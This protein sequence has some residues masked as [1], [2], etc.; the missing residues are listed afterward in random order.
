MTLDVNHCPSCGK[1]LSP[2]WRTRCLHCKT[3]FA[4]QLAAARAAA[5]SAARPPNPAAVAPPSIEVDLA[6][7]T[8]QWSVAVVTRQY[9]RRRDGRQRLDEEIKVFA[10]HAYAPVF[11]TQSQGRLSK[12]EAALL[13][14]GTGG[15]AAMSP[16]VGVGGGYLFGRLLGKEALDEK[17]IL[18]VV[19]KRTEDT[20]VSSP[21]NLVS[22]LAR[23]AEL[24]DAGVLAPEEFVAAKRRLLGLE[25]LGSD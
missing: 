3:D 9:S 10:E 12:K 4:P 18:T 13:L 15:M 20:N 21:A 2:Y 5:A 19:F 16:R 17:G 23:L 24:R 25:N 6:E 8:E 7:I 22:E 11:E 1:A 14:A